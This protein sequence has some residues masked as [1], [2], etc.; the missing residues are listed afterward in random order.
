MV[1]KIG[2]PTD[3]DAVVVRI[4]GR[5]GFLAICVGSSAIIDLPCDWV[6]L[7]DQRR[8]LNPSPHFIRPVCVC[9]VAS[10]SCQSC[11]QLKEPTILHI[12]VSSV[13][14]E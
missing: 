9:F 11:S 7:V 4:L 6:L 8:P 2:K 1:V 5:V 14:L 3:Q 10:V 13:S 12:I